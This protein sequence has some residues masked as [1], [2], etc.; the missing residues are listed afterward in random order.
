[1]TMA[2]TPPRK[3]GLSFSEVFTDGSPMEKVEWEK[4]DIRVKDWKTGEVIFAHDNFRVPH[5]WSENAGQIVASKYA[6]GPEGDREGG[7]DD[8][9]NRV[10]NAIMDNGMTQGYFAS[11][12]DALTFRNE[13]QHLCLHQ[14]GAF[15]SPVW[16]NVGIYESRGLKGTG[17]V[18]RWDDVLGV[19]QTTKSYRYPQTSACFIQSV[20][21]NME[22]LMALATSEAM[23]FK[24]GSG[25]G[26][27]FSKI[28]S[29]REKLSTGGVPSGP[30]SFM[31]IYDRIAATIKSGGKCLAPDQPV[32][33]AGGVKTAGELAESGAA[34][35]VL[36]YSKRLGRVA[37]KRANAWKSGVKDIVEVVTDKGRFKVSSD[38]PFMGRDGRAIQAGDLAEGMSLLPIATSNQDGYVRVGLRDGRKGRAL[39]HQLVAKDILGW[40]SSGYSVH[41]ENEIKTDCRPPNLRLK[42]QSAHAADHCA[43]LVAAGEHVFQKRRFGLSGSSNPMHR[44]RY[45]S[46]PDVSRRARLQQSKVLIA[47]GRSAT[48]QVEAV[49]SKMLNVGAALLNDGYD[50]STFEGY[51]AA[52]KAIGRRVPSVPGQVS[53]FNRI[54]GTY[55]NFYLSLRADNHKVIEVNKIG[56]SQVV[57]IEVLD[58]EPDDKRQW[59]EHNYA[60]A[61]IGA[62]DPFVGGVFV[63]NTRRAA[64]MQTLGCWHPDIME[65]IRAKG[66]EERK[67]HMLIAAGMDNSFNGE[68][69]DT[70]AFQNANFTVRVPDLFMSI[71]NDFES[72]NSEGPFR[73]PLE[74]VTTGELVEMMDPDVIWAAIAEETHRCG[75]PGLQFVDTINSWHTCPNSGPINSSNPCSEYLFI[76]DSACNLASL[77]L[78]KFYRD[79][80]FQIDEFKQ[81]IRVFIVAMDILVDMGSYPTRKIAQNQHDYRTLG[82]GF[83]DLGGLLMSMGLAYDSGEGRSVAGAIASMMTA[84][85]YGVSS[86]MA[87]AFGPFG[88]FNANRDSMLAVIC[89]H[90]KACYRGSV[91][92]D[93]KQNNLWGAACGAWVS[94]EICGNIFG[95]RNAQISVIAPTGTIAF[96]MDCDTTGIEP[97]I[98]LVQYKTLAGGGNMKIANDR[99]FDALVALGYKTEPDNKLECLAEGGYIYADDV[100]LILHDIQKHGHAT[101]SAELKPEHL[102]VFDCAL[103]PSGCDR[104]ISYEGH[105]KMMAAVQPFISGA[106]SKTVNVPESFTADQIADVYYEA[107]KLGLKC[108]AIYRDKSKSSQPVTLDKPTELEAFTTI[109]NEDTVPCI[110]CS[111]PN[112][113]VSGT[114]S[115]CPKC[116]TSQG[117]CS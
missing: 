13:L 27:D 15:N 115:V 101:K 12:T 22:S 2:T 112:V 66:N 34:F 10:V 110:N 87:G 57:S 32:Y 7:V 6:F 113:V 72:H 49:R 94:A 50:I 71:V 1:M 48:M 63:L 35:Q 116:G 59:S 103:A 19:V 61:P 69:Y 95:Y 102:D 74:A 93:L 89:K 117:G 26:T 14:Y 65:F 91:D 29:K 96:M 53:K 44:S 16:F 43:V 107:W 70:V 56:K 30:L 52:R 18:Y 111:F 114:C 92:C 24:H 11:T 55:D 5:S 79:G 4:R 33:T 36:S 83:A 39:L 58:D 73:W 105:L 46:N 78:T 76:D 68:A 104:V 42:T 28:R 81:A 60:I 37:V 106:I 90:K 86:E 82:L 40:D 84:E 41:H 67:A 77:R 9:I 80:V 54:F 85:G 47:S 109:V 8:V 100:M 3:G 31:K 23:L 38:H 20:E 51:V 17:S 99:V 108:V 75:D 21:D 62:T 97:P 45:W 25:T 88:G 64:K 98:G